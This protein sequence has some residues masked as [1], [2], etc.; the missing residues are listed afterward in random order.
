M[1]I[2]TIDHRIFVVVDQII[3]ANYDKTAGYSVS[4]FRMCEIHYTGFIV[5]AV[6][7][8]SYSQRNVLIQ[9]PTAK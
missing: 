9:Q 8:N 1:S 6:E 4:S 5:G 3:I 7:G 2:S